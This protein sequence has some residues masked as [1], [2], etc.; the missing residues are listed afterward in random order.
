MCSLTESELE[1]ELVRT[2]LDPSAIKVCK[3][4]KEKPPCV[5][6]RGSDTYCKT[7]FLTAVHHKFRATL[8]K[9]K[10]MRPGESVCIAYS[11]GGA[12]TALLH[13]LKTGIESDHKKLLFKPVV[14][15]VD[16]GAI[17][18]LDPKQRIENIREKLDY[19][20]AH[21]PFKVYVSTLEQ[22]QR[23]VEYKGDGELDLEFEAERT[24]ELYESIENIK[25]SSAKEEFI[26][27]IRRHTILEGAEKI[28]CAKIF[29][30]EN[31][32]KISIDLLTGVSLGKGGNLAQ[33]VGFWD[34]R[35]AAITVL[36][37]LRD[38]PAKEL[39]LYTVF[40]RLE[41]FGE[42]TIGTGKESLFSIRKL[43]EDFLVGLQND[44]PATLSTVFKTS[45]KLQAH[46]ERMVE[47]NQSCVLCDGTLDTEVDQ[48]NA[49]Q[50]TQWS[51]IVSSR[52]KALDTD[53]LNPASLDFLD[54]TSLK[55]AD[56]SCNPDPSND[57]CCGQGDGSCK[58][59]KP[60]SK[61]DLMS[62]A[63]YSCMRTV[64]NFKS[65]EKIPR[66]LH[67]QVQRTRNRNAMKNEIQDFLL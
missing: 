30:G 11:G 10:A 46:Q 18:K 52:G 42:P 23:V 45:D 28:N 36:R 13:L 38:V 64:S 8:G 15:H 7:C 66:K 4:C 55:L 9:H 25:E 35:N 50:A 44:F 53:D 33:E 43:T 63:C 51:T 41:S 49:L 20:A 26:N 21:F 67:E 22:S 47:G 48:H 65:M 14:L 54:L 39:A 27:C 37:P 2:P 12:S 56:P 40:H 61:T 62:L 31:A 58:T 34:K 24:N 16:E 17:F 29:T 59:K 6:L 19:I 5:N 32:T 3:K 1:P 57:E 60:L